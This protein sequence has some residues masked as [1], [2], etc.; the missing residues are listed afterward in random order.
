[1]WVHPNWLVWLL[2]GSADVCEQVV[3]RGDLGQRL[4]AVDCHD[5]P[6]AVQH[7]RP[8]F[9][10]PVDAP[11][12]DRDGDLGGRRN[13]EL[14]AIEA[15]QPS[16]YACV[17]Q[18]QSPDEGARCGEVGAQ[19]RCRLS[20][21]LADRGDLELVFLLAERTRDLLPGGRRSIF[22][23]TVSVAR[24]AA[25]ATLYL[26]QQCRRYFPGWSHRRMPGQGSHSDG[27]SLIVG[28]MRGGN[29]AYGEQL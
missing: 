22:S 11:V 27:S 28:A 20:L 23:L 3:E 21:L 2:F 14:E 4:A 10:R 13:A 7:V 15:A 24:L 8:V 18:S 16:G 1:L 29:S 26:P 5:E 19:E 6:V 12:V 17:S 25:T 9:D